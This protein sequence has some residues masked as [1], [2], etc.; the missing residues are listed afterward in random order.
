[1]AVGQVTNIRHTPSRLPTCE[2]WGS[3]GV[4]A[5][6]E[7]F[8]SF[9]AHQMPSMMQSL[10]EVTQGKEEM[11]QDGEGPLW[12][13]TFVSNGDAKLQLSPSV[14]SDHRGNL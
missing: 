14:V 4:I 9:L 8:F 6:L 12:F 13:N 2:D 5:Q 1:M 10:A 7:F 3:G 11:R